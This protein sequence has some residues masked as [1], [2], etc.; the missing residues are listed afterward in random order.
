MIREWSECFRRRHKLACV[1]DEDRNEQQGNFLLKCT[2]EKRSS[3]KDDGQS[4]FNV[5]TTRGRLRFGA[6]ICIPGHHSPEIFWREI[7]G[8]LGLIAATQENS[9]PSEKG[10]LS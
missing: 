7:Y 4:I 2:V 9:I 5:P 1:V 3:G 6:P 8:T 10:R